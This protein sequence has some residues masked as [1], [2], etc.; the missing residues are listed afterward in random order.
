[1]ITLHFLE[2]SRAHRIIWLLEELSVE[3]AIEKYQRDPK[4]LF[5]PE[6]LQKIHPL[7][8]SPVIYDSETKITLAESGAI[9]EYL[10]SRYDTGNN[11]TLNQS[12]PEYWQ[13]IYWL[14]FCEGTLMTPLLFTVV[15]DKVKTSPMPFF[16]RPI[17]K[18]IAN[19]VMS[20]FVNPNIKRLLTYANKHLENNTWFAGEV[21]SGADIQM[22]YPLD[23]LAENGKLKDYPSLS[24]YVKHLHQLPNYQ[25]ALKLGGP[26]SL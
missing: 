26:V 5:A 4:T 19:K 21:L 15:F 13:Y 7:G 2:R 14:H 23:V 20:S 22:S 9:I 24:A 3:Y 10:I 11:L 17:A 6:A 25:K 1:M 8:K 18:Q 12:S 16:A